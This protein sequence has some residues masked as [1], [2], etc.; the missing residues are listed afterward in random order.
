[1]LFVDYDH[2]QIFEGGE[3][4][5]S[6]ANSDWCRSRA[7]PLPLFEALTGSQPTVQNGEFVTEAT[8]QAGKDLMG[9]AYFGNHHEC[10]SPRAK[11]RVD[12]A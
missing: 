1:V 11:R 12:G 7:K 4:R 10:L 6:R 9:E 8:P 3:E 5:G 2:T